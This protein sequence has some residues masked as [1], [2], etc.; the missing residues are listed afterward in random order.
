MFICMQSDRLKQVLEHL[1]TLNSLCLVLGM[2]FQ[3]TVNE[4]HPSLG[5]SDGT[6]SIS[7]S[8]IDSLAVA[9]KRLLEL[10]IQRMQRVIMLAQNATWF[11]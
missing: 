11:V 4:V 7:D 2:D 5:D 9:I 8:T 3:Q 1:S 10:K 6:K